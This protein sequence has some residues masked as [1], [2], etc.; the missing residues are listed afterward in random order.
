MGTDLSQIDLDKPLADYKTE[1][2]QGMLKG[3]AESAEDK[4]WTFR[5]MV[6]ATGADR[7]VGTPEH[8]A[9]ELQKW[10]DA[11][12]DGINLNGQDGEN[13]Y[14]FLEHATPVLQERGLMQREY[15]S[16]TLRDKL[17]RR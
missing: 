5:D 12:I 13:T 1:S 4:T 14:D 7:I 9:D 6:R 16:G 3:F 10:R 11:G 15:R 8:I 17:F 2:L